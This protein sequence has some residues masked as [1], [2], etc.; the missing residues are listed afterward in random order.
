MNVGVICRAKGFEDTRMK[1]G[2]WSYPVDG[3]EWTFYP[4]KDSECVDLAKLSAPHDVLVYEDWA[5]PHLHGVASVPV[6]AVVVDSNTSERRFRMYHERVKVAD[7]ILLDQEDL[8]RFADLG[9]PVYRWSYGVNEHVFYPR[10]KITDVGYHVA[11]TPERGEF[12]TEL[13]HWVRGTG[14]SYAMG[15]GMACEEYAVKVGEAKILIHLATHPQCRSHRFFDALASGCCLLSNH[16]KPVRE[17]G[18]QIRRHFMEWATLGE[19]ATQIEHLLRTGLWETIA[20]EGRQFVLENH[21]WKHRASEFISIV[22]EL[23]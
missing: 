23:V 17:D 6:L 11:R 12:A 3:L 13:L 22:E 20:Q 7:A 18:F 1:L 19:L 15:G 4:V 8:R 9:R 16:V 10:P 5:W 2:W 14:Y 21:T